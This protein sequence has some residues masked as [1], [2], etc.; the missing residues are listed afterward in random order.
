MNRTYPLAIA[1]ASV[2][3]ATA[4]NATPRGDEIQAPR[5]QEIQAPRDQ[6]VQAPRKERS[7]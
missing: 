5:D 7:G 6:D 2:L 3:T 4:A 1:L